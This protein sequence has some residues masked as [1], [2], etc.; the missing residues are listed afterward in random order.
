RSLRAI[1]GGGR[2]DN[3]TGAVGGVE[4]PA[5][6]FGMGDVVLGELLKEKGKVPAYAGSIDVFVVGDA[7]TPAVL[8]LTHDLRDAGIRAEF[9]LGG[10]TLSKQQDIAKARNARL[11]ITVGE[12][13]LQ[14]K[15]LG[16]KAPQHTVPRTSAVAEIS[17]LLG[18]ATD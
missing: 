7:T 3:L 5:V 4:L 12:G 18:R 17:K 9:A 10:Q 15:D 14:V 6:G 13:E 8:K 1:C 11:L 2:Y 16:T